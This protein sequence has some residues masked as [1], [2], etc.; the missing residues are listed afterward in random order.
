MDVIFSPSP[1]PSKDQ[2]KNV[3]EK[4]GADKEWALKKL[5]REAKGCLC[6][7]IA[8]A[9]GTKTEESDSMASSL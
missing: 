7:Q 8:P 6:V 4:Q 2:L 5:T 9:R 1:S 3:L